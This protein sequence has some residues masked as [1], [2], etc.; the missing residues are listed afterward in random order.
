MT[1]PEPADDEAIVFEEFFATGLRMP[2]HSALTE[3][4]IKF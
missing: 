1:I 3:I 4:L 2:P